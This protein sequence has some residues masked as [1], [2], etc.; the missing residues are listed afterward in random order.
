MA[1]EEVKEEEKKG[2][3][4]TRIRQQQ[5]ESRCWRWFHTNGCMCE[6]PTLSIGPDEFYCKVE[7]PKMKTKDHRKGIHF[8]LDIILTEQ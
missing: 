8:S 3:M 1:D 2:T 6:L 5:Y 4:T 7:A